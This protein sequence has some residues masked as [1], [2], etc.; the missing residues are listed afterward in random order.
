M[1]ILW[2][3]PFFLHP[4][5][6]GAQIRSLGILQQLHRRHEIHFATLED[7]ASSEGRERS[8]E[9]STRAYPVPH[10]P[11]KRGSAA[12]YFQAVAGMFSRTPLAVSRYRSRQLHRI[13]A[14]LAASQKFDAVVC[15]FLASAPNIPD[16]RSCVLFQHNVETT[17]SEEHTSELQSLRH[18]VC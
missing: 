1:R 7:P 12:F 9:Y 8:A 3:S 6:R 11:P 10:Q 5:D 16:L 14:E 4:T 13:V 17:R 2:V 18:L 15:D